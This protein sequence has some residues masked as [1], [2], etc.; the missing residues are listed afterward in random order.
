MIA[1]DC[2]AASMVES[3]RLLLLKTLSIASY[4]WSYFAVVGRLKLPPELLQWMW[5]V[6]PCHEGRAFS[7]LSMTIV[8][9][10]TFGI[11]INTLVASLILFYLVRKVWLGLTARRNVTRA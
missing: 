10:L 6:M 7:G 1:L 11:W 2:I 5:N 9:V 4:P 3:S 8:A